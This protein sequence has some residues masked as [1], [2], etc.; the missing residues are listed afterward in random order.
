MQTDGAGR[1]IL[2][3]Q[4]GVTIAGAGAWEAAT[5]AGI[6]RAAVIETD[7]ETLVVVK[8]TVTP[9]QR[10]RM[11]LADNRATDLSS[12]DTARP[13]QLQAQAPEVL[14]T[15]WT[16]QELVELLARAAPHDGRTDPDAVP[17]ARLTTIERG[18]LFALGAHRLLCGDSTDAA[19]VARALGDRRPPLM[20]T[21]PPYGVDYDPAWRARAGVNR[22]TQKLGV[23]TNDDRA[24]WTK[25]WRLFPGDVAYVWQC[26]PSCGCGHPLH[27]LCGILLRRIDLQR[28]LVAG[29]RLCLLSLLF[30]DAS[31]PEVGARDGRLLVF[32]RVREVLLQRLLAARDVRRGKR[33]DVTDLKSTR[34]CTR[35][36]VS[37]LTRTRRLPTCSSSPSTF[38]RPRRSS[39]RARMRGAPSADPRTLCG[40]G[41]A[42]SRPYERA[43]TR[44]DRRR[45]RASGVRWPARSP[46]MCSLRGRREPAD[47][48]RSAQIA[49]AR[50]SGR[51]AR[52]VPIPP[53]PSLPSASPRTCPRPRRPDRRHCRAGGGSRHCSV[54]ARQPS[55]SIRPPSGRRRVRWRRGQAGRAPARRFSPAP[56]VSAPAHPP[57]A[58]S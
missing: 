54:S 19:D 50:N 9:E 45:G 17:D 22:N 44:D 36:R 58:P 3:D 51:A 2:V 7:G 13:Q 33:R 40:R 4:H 27:R 48:N 20:V 46:R 38:G 18:D 29:L 11:A 26:G 39:A 42:S 14:K 37:R 34:A 56:P 5:R 32:R 16:A 55:R 8:R 35:G 15:L 47:G 52:L 21:D 28:R 30:V 6:T 25:A 49:P 31:K 43:R 10:L 12:W 41:P 53:W 23:V 57:T 24:D 1:S